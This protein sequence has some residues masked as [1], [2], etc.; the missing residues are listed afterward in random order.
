[1][2][3]SRVDGVKAPQHRGTPR[4]YNDDWGDNIAKVL[5]RRPGPI[6]QTAIPTRLRRDHP[7]AHDRGPDRAAD[8]L[9]KTEHQVHS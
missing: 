2:D 3:T 8:G 1:M 9:K 7:V 6:N 4:S 5:V